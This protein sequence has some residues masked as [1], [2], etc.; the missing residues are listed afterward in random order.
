MIQKKSEK[1]GSTKIFFLAAGVFFL[2]IAASS[3]G[4]QELTPMS[5]NSVGANEI[6]G[7]PV[8]EM[9]SA[10]SSGGL[11]GAQ[12]ISTLKQDVGGQVLGSS[13][14]PE[15]PSSDPQPVPPAPAFSSDSL[16][17]LESQ[18]GLSSAPQAGSADTPTVFNLA[19][20]FFEQVVFKKDVE[21]ASRPMFD[22]GLDISGQPTFD[23]DTA[24]YAIIQKGNQ[25]VEV[26]FDQTYDSPPVV[27]ATLSLQQYKDPDVRA[28]AEDLLLVSDVKYII[29]N[30][31]K[32]SFEIMMD[33]KAD[34]DIPFSWHALA[35]NDPATAKK[36]GEKLKSKIG[37]D[38]SP[39]STG[40]AVPAAAGPAAVSQSNTSH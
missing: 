13:I 2:V 40:A 21:F 4:A 31:S 14:S 9:I 11:S 26:D 29:T 24:G 32:K 8:S 33:H 5:A 38:L 15:T 28:V 39:G 10:A 37:N 3:A 22:Q 19:V 23:K 36:K 1:T 34:S 25:S 17:D 6:L 7:T 30:V 35:V 18:G 27:T 12:N 16:K 20:K